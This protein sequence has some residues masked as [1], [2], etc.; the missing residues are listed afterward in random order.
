MGIQINDETLED[1]SGADHFKLYTKATSRQHDVYLSDSVDADSSNYVELLHFFHNV[2]EDDTIN[3]HLANFGGA[4]HSGLR[5]AHAIKCC[6]APVIIY[7][8]A[9]CYSMGAIL[10]LTG[11]ALYMLPGTFLM[12]HNYSTLESGKAAEVKAAINQYENHFHY[13]L[14]YF[15][16]PFLSKTELNKLL[17]DEDIY[18]HANDSDIAKRMIRH[19]PNVKQ[20]R[21]LA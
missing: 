10:A 8:D 5:L 19:F 17:K 11:I 1:S 4:C 18:V 15:C 14:K 7:V 6:K 16:S 2:S 13:S 20:Y 21:V 12:F 3:V 9:P